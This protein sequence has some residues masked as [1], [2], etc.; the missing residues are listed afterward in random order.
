M[1]LA[2]PK[3]R[4]S[5]Y[6]QAVVEHLQSV[7]GDQVKTVRTHGGSFTE[8]DLKQIL[9]NAPALHVA[10]LGIR[11]TAPVASGGVDITIKMSV[12]VATHNQ[13]G[14][15]ADECA[16]DLAPDMI[17]ALDRWQPRDLGMFAA[18]PATG[19]VFQNLYSSGQLATG[20]MLSALTFDASLRLTKDLGEPV[21]GG[22]LAGTYVDG[23]MVEGDPSLWG[24]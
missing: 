21:F 15:P 20:Q 18:L 22:A 9:A 19:M 8:A 23:A 13:A 14:Y 1:S 10:V 2:R 12:F 5:A 4:I 17:M 6:R 24:L 3:G 7:L 16:L 11:P